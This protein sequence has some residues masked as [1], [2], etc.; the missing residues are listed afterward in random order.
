MPIENN[1][2]PWW[3]GPSKAPWEAMLEGVQAGSQIRSNQL[4]TQQLAAQTAQEFERQETAAKIKMMDMSLEK[5]RNGIAVQAYQNKALT[6]S[7]KAKALTEVSSFMS[8]K[9]AEG[10][11][12]EPETLSELYSI[13]SRW[14]SFID[15][16]TLNGII[17]HSIKPAQERAEKAKA[18][19]ASPK[20]IVQDGVKFVQDPNSGDWRQVSESGQT[21]EA[22]GP[23]GQ[24]ISRVSSGGKP[25]SQNPDATIATQTDVQKQAMA[26]E[27]AVTTGVNLL[28]SLTPDVVGARGFF[29]EN[30]INEGLAQV[31]PEMNKGEVTSGR[32][33]MRAFNEKMIKSI[34]ADSQLNQS[35]RK[36]L[37]SALPQFGVNESLPSAKKKIATFIEESR[38]TTRINA[39]RTKRPIPDWAWTTDEI[40][41]KF[42]AGEI[43][44]NKARQLLKQFHYKLD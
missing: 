2:L 17:T 42:K 24:L 43:D 23:D 29:N 10:K 31:F 5:E 32:S 38:K 40:A 33:M 21:I 14:A 1:S 11:L 25:S 16:Q 13:G 4:R 8:T 18:L 35:E 9:A 27:S 19:G 6:E 12:A 39:E 34:K 30:I 37:E 22:Y 28:N 20:T 36:A 3:L 7:M 26:G 15:D 44:E 41:S